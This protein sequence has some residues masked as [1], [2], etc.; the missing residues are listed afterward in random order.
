MIV[1]TS[2]KKV[3]TTKIDDNGFRPKFWFY[4]ACYQTVTYNKQVT[5]NTLTSNTL[6]TRMKHSNHLNK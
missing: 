1:V 5:L 2:W 6:D 3:Y 4:N